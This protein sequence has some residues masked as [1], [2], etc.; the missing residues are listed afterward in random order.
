MTKLLVIDDERSIL[1]MLELSLSREG[2][3]VLTAEN[4]EKG[5][6][7]F[8]EHR[9]K[10]VLTD[11]KMPGIDGIEVLK[12]IKAIDPEAEVIV[13]TGHGDMDTAIAALQH[14]ASDFVTKPIRDDVLMVSLQRAEKRV[15][16]SEQL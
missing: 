12:R 2:Y 11:V 4:G 10:L 15:A 7:S 8:Q 3:E 13:I 14:Q 1:E 6:S 16:M 9:P 5:V